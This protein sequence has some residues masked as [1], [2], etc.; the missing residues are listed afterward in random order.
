MTQRDF[1]GENVKNVRLREE[2]S[3]N[4]LFRVDDVKNIDTCVV[5]F[6]GNSWEKRIFSIH[7]LNPKRRP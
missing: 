2:R 1:G 6:A 5:E 4:Y 3:P 7:Q